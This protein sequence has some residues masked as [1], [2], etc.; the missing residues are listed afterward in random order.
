MKLTTHVH[1]V[2]KLK[3][4]AIML[5]PLYVFVACLGELYHMFQS[6]IQFYY[7]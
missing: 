3:S 7:V 5:L 2:P 4:G 6:K 1:V